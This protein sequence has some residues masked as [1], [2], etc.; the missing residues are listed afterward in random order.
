[1]VLSHISYTFFG[2]F[3]SFSFF[4]IGLLFNPAQQKQ[5]INQAW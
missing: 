3:I 5:N 2:D 4:V 1:L